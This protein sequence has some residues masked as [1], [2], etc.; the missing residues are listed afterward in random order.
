MKIPERNA[1]R[2]D[3]VSA[4]REIKDRQYLW[5]TGE[6]AHWQAGGLSSKEQAG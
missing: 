5:L 2:G 1:P 4:D 6:L 3:R